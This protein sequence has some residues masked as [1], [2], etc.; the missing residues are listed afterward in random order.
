MLQFPSLFKIKCHIFKHNTA[1]KG[2][3]LKV[4]NI[5]MNQFAKKASFSLASLSSSISCNTV[6]TSCN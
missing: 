3:T 2:D 1:L 6:N 4:N 5:R